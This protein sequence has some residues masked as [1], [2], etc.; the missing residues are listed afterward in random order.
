MM[1]GVDAPSNQRLKNKLNLHLIE[2]SVLCAQTF[3]AE[4]FFNIALVLM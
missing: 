4:N 2:P 1:V 3:H